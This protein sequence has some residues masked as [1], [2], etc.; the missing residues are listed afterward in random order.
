M[1][2]PSCGTEY[3][4]GLPYCNRCGANLNSSLTESEG[5]VSV[6]VTKAVAAIGTTMAVLTLGGFIS[7]IV[8]AV[9]LAQI[10]SMGTAPLVII[11]TLGM[12][13][14]LTVDVFLALHLSRLIGAGISNKATSGKRSIPPA[15]APGQLNRP[16]TSP[17]PPS[18]SVTENT[19]R[20][21]E[22]R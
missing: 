11:M 12:V 10:T 20:F 15:S 18:M 14:I 3:S 6:D 9:K 8:G 17:P 16:L 22:P 13:T 5:Q 7:L 21:L 19:T 2:C 4:V 1:F